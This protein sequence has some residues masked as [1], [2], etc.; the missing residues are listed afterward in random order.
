[1]DMTFKFV[2]MCFSIA[3]R[4]IRLTKYLAGKYLRRC[5][6][7]NYAYSNYSCKKQRVV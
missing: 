2:T 4:C 5:K 6:G 7:G 3:D 1:M